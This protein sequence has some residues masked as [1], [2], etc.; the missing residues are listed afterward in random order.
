[1]TNEQMQRHN[2]RTAAAGTFVS[3][4]MQ[5]IRQYGWFE[6]FY[7]AIMGRLARIGF[8]LFQVELGDDRPDIAKPQLPLGYA[9]RAVDLEELRPWV[10]KE[11][12][13][14]SDEFVRG[15]IARG[16]RCV[17]NFFHDQLVGYGFVTQVGAPVTDQLEVVI[18]DRLIYRY[19][20]WTHPDHRRKHLSHAR[21]RLNRQLFPLTN[22]RRTIDYVAVHNLASKLKHADVHPEWLGYCGYVRLFGREYPF[23]QRAPRRSGFRLV[24][25]GSSNRR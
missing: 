22:G 8:H 13:G 11:G 18:D 14:L 25:R 23:T 15:A 12:Y 10:S 21:G 9:T 19:K 24:R 17:A 5:R 6:V 2:G 4:T 7:T 16:D 3:M 1:L 20:G